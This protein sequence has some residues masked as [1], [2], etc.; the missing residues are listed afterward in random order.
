MI[1]SMSDGIPCNETTI[2]AFV[3]FVNFFL[4]VSAVI[5]KVSGSTSANT[6][7]ALQ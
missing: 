2:I 3:F 6:G 4:I 1:G 7:L 5:K